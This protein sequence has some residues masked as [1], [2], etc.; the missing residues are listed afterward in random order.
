MHQKHLTK[1]KTHSW[2]KTL[3]KLGI[4]EN[5]LSLMK[6]IYEKPTANIIF[7]GKKLEAF[8]WR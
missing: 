6:N 1:L 2:L 5:I 3:L 7:N 4:E 8:P